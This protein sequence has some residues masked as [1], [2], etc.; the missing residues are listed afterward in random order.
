MR[1]R[2]AGTI[3]PR[4]STMVGNTT[5]ILSFQPSQSSPKAPRSVRLLVLL[6]TSPRSSLVNQTTSFFSLSLSRPD[7]FLGHAP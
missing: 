1:T 7:F 5:M 2:S 4:K 6:R 3:L